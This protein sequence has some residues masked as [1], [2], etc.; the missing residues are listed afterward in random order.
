MRS[1]WCTANWEGSQLT[2]NDPK[3]MPQNVASCSLHRAAGKRNSIQSNGTHLPESPLCMMEPCFPRDGG[4]PACPWQVVNGFLLH[5]WMKWGHFWV[6]FL[7]YLLSCLYLNPQVLPF[8]PPTLS[9]TPPEWS[10]GEALWGWVSC[11]VK[12]RHLQDWA[13]PEACAEFECMSEIA[14]NTQIIQ[15]VH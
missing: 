1:W 8:A 9:T 15:A 2:P 5:F 10:E 3:D 13:V 4:T 6:Q 11:G 12:P 7:L 14:F